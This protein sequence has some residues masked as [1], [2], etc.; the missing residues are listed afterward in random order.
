MP[1]ASMI[2]RETS[3]TYKVTGWRVKRKATRTEPGREARGSHE[4]SKGVKAETGNV[5]QHN[6][7]LARQQALHIANSPQENMGG[8]TALNPTMLGQETCRTYLIHP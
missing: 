4:N 1:M 2:S 3:Y 6:R 8:Y 7:F 5:T